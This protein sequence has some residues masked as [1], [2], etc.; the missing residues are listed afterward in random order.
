MVQYKHAYSTKIAQIYVTVCTT[1]IM[2]N[3][4]FLE[5]FPLKQEIDLFSKVRS[6]DDQIL[7]LSFL[8]YYLFHFNFILNSILTVYI[9]LIRN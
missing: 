2:T 5:Q 8:N 3:S 6:K 7:K 4:Y 1:L 9:I